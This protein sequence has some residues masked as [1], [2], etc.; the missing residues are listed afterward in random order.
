M[1]LGFLTDE[2]ISEK[3]FGLSEAALGAS[4]GGTS[5]E[6]NSVNDEMVEEITIGT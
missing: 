4:F 2:F 5:Q 3:R 6:F 1:L